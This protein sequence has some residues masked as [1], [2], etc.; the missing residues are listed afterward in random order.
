MCAKLMM[1]VVVVLALWIGSVS[2]V[3]PEVLAK[4]RIDK[5][6]DK[7]TISDDLLLQETE[8]HLEE[9]IST[10]KKMLENTLEMTNQ[11]QIENDERVNKLEEKLREQMES[12]LEISIEE[13]MK[14]LEDATELKMTNTLSKGLDRRISRQIN[15]FD[16]MPMSWRF[17]FISFVIVLLGIGVIVYKKYKFLIKNQL[18]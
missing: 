12:H 16:K 2:A 14:A 11:L 4:K 15:K 13:R 3:A 7:L 5:L 17:P 10:I 18:L 6:L 8:K 9:Q 1:I